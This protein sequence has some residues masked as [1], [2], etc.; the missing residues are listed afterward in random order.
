MYNEENEIQERLE[1]QYDQGWEDCKKEILKIIAEHENATHW[2]GLDWE[3]Q[4][5]IKKIKKL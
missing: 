2:N 3:D 1:W 4:E 5:Y